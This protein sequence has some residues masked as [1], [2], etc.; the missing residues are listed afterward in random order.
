MEIEID[1]LEELLKNAIAEFLESSDTLLFTMDTIR[2]VENVLEIIKQLTSKYKERD[3]KDDKVQ[4][5][6]KS[7]NTIVKCSFIY[8]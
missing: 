6:L 4:L 3:F 1:R 7:L 8:W 5:L 2:S